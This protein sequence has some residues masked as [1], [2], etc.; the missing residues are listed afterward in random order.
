MIVT[1]LW[2]CVSTT[3]EALLFSMTSRSIGRPATEDKLIGGRFQVYLQY[4]VVMWASI[5][6]S[7]GRFNEFSPRVYRER[8]PG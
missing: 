8:R 1:G 4:L 5:F 3:A 6:C 2:P 7:A